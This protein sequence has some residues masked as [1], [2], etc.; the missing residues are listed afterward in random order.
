MVIKRVSLKLVCERTRNVSS[1][2]VPACKIDDR[3]QFRFNIYKY[4][5]TFTWNTL[6]IIYREKKKK[7]IK[8]N[9]VSFKANFTKLHI[10][11]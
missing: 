4:K 9:L 1:F 6:N 10:F 5:G 3:S 7:T 8:T 11:L 2:S